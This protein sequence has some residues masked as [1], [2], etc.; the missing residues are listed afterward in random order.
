MAKLTSR[1]PIQDGL[2]IY[3]QDNSK[4]W[5][6]RFVIDAEWYSKATKKTD[7]QEAI[8]R[9]LE[10]LSEYRFMVKHDIPILHI[11]RAT[12]YL[13]PNVADLAIQR[14]ESELS[15]GMGKVSYE[16]YIQSL[17]KYHK[18]FF[19]KT[20]ISDIDRKLLQ[21]FDS[22]RT[23]KLGRVPAKSTILTHNAAFSRVFDEA[24]IQTYMVTSQRPNLNN[25]GI[26]SERRASFTEEEFDHLVVEAYKFI[27][28]A[29]TN[30]SKM[31]R[32]LL[33]D[34]IVVAANT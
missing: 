5:Y 25:T 27:Q 28:K 18:V 26:A 13:F 31:I 11:K 33:V 20:S 6:A 22:W 9:A 34:Y 15:K 29:R 12:K 19:D 16:G 3:Q 30:K 8:H 21:E 14:M 17:N 4:Y 2:Y 32:E 7:K 23:S 1:H 10:L 24:V